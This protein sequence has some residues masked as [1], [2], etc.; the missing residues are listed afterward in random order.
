MIDTILYERLGIEPSSTEEEIKK[1]G[2]KL[3]LKYHPD[4]N[5]N[6]EEATKKF[7]EIKEALDILTDKQKREL[8]HINGIKGANNINNINTNENQNIQRGFPF[9]FPFQVHPGMGQPRM[10]PEFMFNFMNQF[11]SSFVHMNNM[12]NAKNAKN[13]KNANMKEQRDIN[14][15][16]K[17]EEAT[18]QEKSSFDI[19]YNRNVY[20]NECKGKGVLEQNI[21]INNMTITSFNTCQKCGGRSFFIEQKKVVINLDKEALLKLIKENESIVIIDQGNV[22]EN[23]TTNLNIKFIF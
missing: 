6:K 17:V 19:V 14:C 8:Y 1:E 16:I 20:C 10:P 9:P 18:I 7:I 21:N 4:K 22:Y 5:E 3:L 11:N 12:N 2:K 23:K 15:T 13:A